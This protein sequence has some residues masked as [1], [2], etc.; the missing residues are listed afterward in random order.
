MLGTHKPLYIFF[1]CT[2]TTERYKDEIL[3]PYVLFFL[4]GDVGDQLILRDE[5]VRPYWSA[6][7]DNYLEDGIRHM[8]WPVRCRDLKHSE[9]LLDVLARVI[10]SRQL[11][12]SR[13]QAHPYVKQNQAHTA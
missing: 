8:V 6:L 5:N 4:C 1:A 7:V 9:N 11:P 3:E 2:V 10:A 12:L 13:C